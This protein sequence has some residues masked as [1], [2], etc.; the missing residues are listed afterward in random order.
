MNKIKAIEFILIGLYL[1]YFPVFLVAILFKI[2]YRIL[3]WPVYRNNTEYQ[4]FGVLQD[5][6][7]PSSVRW[8]WNFKIIK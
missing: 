4:T 1:I 3:I 2:I 7:E 8:G 6:V 5:I